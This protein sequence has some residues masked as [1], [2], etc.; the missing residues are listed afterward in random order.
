MS[1]PKKSSRTRGIAAIPTSSGDGALLAQ[2]MM[3]G[4]SRVRALPLLG[5]TLAQKQILA[6]LAGEARKYH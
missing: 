1:K 6:D 4:A 3:P 2:V 5:D